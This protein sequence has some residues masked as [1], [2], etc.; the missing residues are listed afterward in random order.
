MHQAPGGWPRR[1]PGRG[2]SFFH[3]G[4]DPDSVAAAVDGQDA[5]IVCLGSSGLR[6][7]TTLSRGTRTIV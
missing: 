5:A 7:S 2:V 3:P 6:D 1:W 4:F